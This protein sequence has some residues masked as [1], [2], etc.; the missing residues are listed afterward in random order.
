MPCGDH[1]MA[2]EE[3]W[4][5]VELEQRF[6]H[7]LEELVRRFDRSTSYCSRIVPTGQT[8][9]FQLVGVNS[10]ATHFLLPQDKTTALHTRTR[11]VPAWNRRSGRRTTWL[12]HE[13]HLRCFLGLHQREADVFKK[14]FYRHALQTSGFLKGAN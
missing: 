8:P 2:L 6:G 10:S 13:Y 12:H 5:L 14:T 4:L 3:G 9:A 11:F 1:E 7:G